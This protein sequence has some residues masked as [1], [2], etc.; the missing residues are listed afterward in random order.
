[1]AGIFDGILNMFGGG[2]GEQAAQPLATT[3]DVL[4]NASG[5][6]MGLA[7]TMVNFNDLVSR[8]YANTGLGIEEMISPGTFGLRRDA[9]GSI[10]KELNLGSSI[11]P[12]LQNLL[13][14]KSLE[15]GSSA[16]AGTS[17]FG[18]N[19]S[20]DDLLSTGIDLGRQR[21]MDALAAS[22]YQQYVQTQ[23]PSGLISGIAQDIRGR[24][25]AMNAQARIEQNQK[26]QK[27]QQ[28][29][30]TGL[31][32]AGTVAGGFFGSAGGPLGTIAGASAGGALG[33]MAGGMLFG[34]EQGGMGGGGGNQFTSL[35]SGL[36]GMGGGGGVSTPGINPAGGGLGGSNWGLGGT[37]FAR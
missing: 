34:G 30:K 6:A 16:G 21:R 29:F 22:P 7:P 1:M 24:E 8:G 33:N 13:T 10:Q 23:D 18:F 12:E 3:S 36:G 2:G 5:L 11:P 26:S 20:L 37:M 28:L 19:I 14:Q 32:I 17:D 35:L 9:L 4:G 15:R 31:S 25:A 27:S